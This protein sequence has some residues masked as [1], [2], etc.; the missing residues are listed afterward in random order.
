MNKQKIYDSFPFA[1]AIINNK[2]QVLESNKNF[3]KLFCEE[4]EI[5]NIIPS[6]LINIKEQEF[7]FN[8]EKFNVIC[9][10][11]DT[12]KDN[13]SLTFLK[14]NYLESKKTLVSLIIIDNYEEVLDTLEEFRHP[15]LLA[16]VDRKI[17]KMAVDLGGV[18]KNFEKD[19][20]LFIVS[21]DK[22]EIL[23]ENKFSILESVREIEMGNTIPVTLSI[24]IGIDGKDLNQNMDFARSAIDLAL[25]R[26]GDQVI[27]KDC[28]SYQF[29]GGHSKETVKNDRVRARV[30]AYALADML[31]TASNVIIMGHKNIDLDCLGAAIGIYAISKGFE[32]KCKI[33]LDNVSY[34]V[35]SLYNQI[36]KE[37]KYSDAFIQSKDALKLVNKKTLLIVVDT[38]KQSICEYPEIIDKAKSIV[39]FDHHRKGAQYIDKAVLSYHEPYA[40]STCE[41]ITEMLMYI[42]KPISIKPFE[43]D[44]IL[45]GMIVDTK[46]FIFKTGIKTFEAAAFLKKKGAD[47]TRV[48][49]LF[50]TNIEEYSAEFEAIK[51]AEFF[52]EK[53]AITVLDNSIK[54]PLLI[55][56]TTA[57]KLLSLENVEASFVLCKQAKYI[58][59]S[60]RSFGS[61]NVQFIMEML[62]GGGH[63]IAA[64]TQ[65]KNATVDEAKQL[66]K[67]AINQYLK[68]EN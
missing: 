18:V 43:A 49:S 44:A 36:I 50:R 55:T 5:L 23:K 1:Y 35:K 40:S 34:A 9:E 37:E 53:M 33:I 46:N 62:G 24:G 42:N 51:K 30:K 20:Y 21:Q 28:E 10:K 65:I 16:V 3:K 48:K 22:L 61:I 39:V 52:C 63:Q 58:Y 54:N 8:D 47:T 26:G 7:V 25:G 64:A 68:E 41:L 57:D 56:A 14:E 67:D 4:T 45:A 13:F 59:I 27:I 66:L 12:D 17:K 6:F 29:F 38:Y 31:E 11:V 15:L 19:K 60:A 2:S 32:K